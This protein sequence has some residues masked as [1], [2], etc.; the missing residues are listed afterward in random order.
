MMGNRVQDPR[1]D[2]KSSAEL[3]RAQPGRKA[4]SPRR[5]FLLRY[6][7]GCRKWQDKAHREVSPH[8]TPEGLGRPPAPSPDSLEGNG[9]WHYRAP[10]PLQRTIHRPHLVLPGARSWW[11]PLTAR[12]GALYEQCNHMG[13]QAPAFRSG[14][15]CAASSLPPTPFQGS[16]GSQAWPVVVAPHWVAERAVVTAHLDPIIRPGLEAASAT[17]SV[18]LEAG[19][20][21]ER[22]GRESAS[23]TEA[24]RRASRS[25]LP[26]GAIRALCVTL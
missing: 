15:R 18:K 5:P 17:S 25:S 8:P 20:G 19:L 24:G 21:G 4:P 26:L 2:S 23:A 12:T 6:L 3:Y 7:T 16:K 14:K 1:A 11:A 9:A 13:T 22:R 10:G